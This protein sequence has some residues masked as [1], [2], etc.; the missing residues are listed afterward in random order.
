KKESKLKQLFRQYGKAAVIVYVGL[1]LVDLP[2]CYLLVERVGE[3]KI[4][5][6]TSKVKGFFGFGKEDFTEKE[7]PT[8]TN[9][10]STIEDTVSNVETSSGSTNSTLMSESF[11]TK[12]AIAYG[13]HKSLIF[14]R[15]PLTASI[16]PIIVRYLQRLGFNIGRTSIR[17]VYSVGKEKLQKPDF[18]ASNEKFGSRPSKKQKWW[19]WFF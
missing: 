13:I 19:S 12:F 4:H 3:D 16:T 2:L 7:D 15:V 9:Q 14:I 6:F 10:K 11:L 18:T 5:E 17:S 8:N 1:C